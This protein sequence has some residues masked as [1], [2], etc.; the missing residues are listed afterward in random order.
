MLIRR[1]YLF[2]DARRFS[3]A[4]HFKNIEKQVAGCGWKIRKPRELSENLE[5][6]RYNGKNS[7]IG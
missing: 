1:G 4:H 5:L 6:V 3:G 7:N 2:S